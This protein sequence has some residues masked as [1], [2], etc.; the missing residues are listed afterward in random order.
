MYEGPGLISVF[1]LFCFDVQGLGLGLG[2]GS[3]YGREHNVVH[4]YINT[5]Y[6]YNYTILE[7]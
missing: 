4:T 5:R 2:L 7:G 3:P 6:G 1:S